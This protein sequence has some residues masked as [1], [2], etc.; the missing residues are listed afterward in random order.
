MSAKFTQSIAMTKDDTRF[1][2][3]FDDGSARQYFT[4]KVSQNGLKNTL[5]CALM[6]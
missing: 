6:I 5:K 3:S 4:L 2:M 1:V